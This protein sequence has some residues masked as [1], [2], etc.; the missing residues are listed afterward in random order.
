MSTDLDG[1]FE[2]EIPAEEGGG[3]FDIGILLLR[4]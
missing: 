1:K 4:V 3:I 2:F